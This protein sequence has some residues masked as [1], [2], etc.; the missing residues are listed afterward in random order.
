MQKRV[1]IIQNDVIDTPGTLIPVLESR[2]VKFDIISPY[3]SEPV[4]SNVDNWSGLIVLGGPQAAYETDIYPYLN[5][6]MALMRSAVSSDIP[7]LGIC[8]GAQLLAGAFGARVYK[9]TVKEIGW[10]PISLTQS[11]L[12]DL[13]FNAAR[14]AWRY[15]RA[16]S[17]C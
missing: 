10:L 12:D 8:L 17:K 4:P 6:E 1:L 11:G 9:N 14:M 5:D 2:G 15:I 3:K 7:V 13:L 16:S